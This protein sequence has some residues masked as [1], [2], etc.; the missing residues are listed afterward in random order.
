MT[1]KDYDVYDH[2][3]GTLCEYYHIFQPD[4]HRAVA[5]AFATGKLFLKLVEEK[6]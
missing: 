3:L 5:D 4:Q 6:Q 1:D 2:K